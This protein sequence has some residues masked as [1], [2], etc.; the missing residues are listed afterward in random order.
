MRVGLLGGRAFALALAALFSV[1]ADAGPSPAITLPST[2]DATT[3]T[4]ST[5]APNWTYVLPI[6]LEPRSTASLNITVTASSL[7]MNNADPVKLLVRKDGVEDNSSQKFTVSGWPGQVV[8]VAEGLRKGT[9][10]GTLAFSV[11]NG[12]KT[13][14]AIKLT[15]TP[16]A[17][18]VGSPPKSS[19]D[20]WNPL[21]W[22]AVMSIALTAPKDHGVDVTPVPF[23]FR[24]TSGSEAEDVSTEGFKFLVGGKQIASA[25]TARL[26]ADTVK[27]LVLEIPGPLMPGKYQGEVKL[28]SPDLDTQTVGF[29]LTVRWFFGLALIPIL[30]GA[31][32][33]MWFRKKVLDIRPRTIVRQAAAKLQVRVRTLLGSGINLA[34]RRTLDA[35]ASR[36]DNERAKA[37]DTQEPA[38]NLVQAAKDA[39]ASEDAKLQCFAD[40]TNARRLLDSV[41]LPDGEDAQLRAK[42][43]ELGGLLADKK[44]LADDAAAGFGQFLQEVQDKL[45]QAVRLA[46]DELGVQIGQQKENIPPR[47]ADAAGKLAAASSFLQDARSALDNADF[48]S[49]QKAF[50]DAKKALI[51]AMAEKEKPPAL[52]AA[53][54]AEIAAAGGPAPAALDAMRAQVALVMNAQDS[55]EALYHYQ[56]VKADAEHA[57]AVARSLLGQGAVAQGNAAAD[58]AS[59]MG[60]GGTPPAVVANLPLKQN[61]PLVA[62]PGQ[63]VAENPELVDREVQRI[64]AMSNVFS[65]AATGALGVLVLWGADPAWGK[66]LDWIVAFFWGLGLGEVSKST[67]TGVA[68]LRST[69]AR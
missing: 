62:I 46:L 43:T 8:L 56:R 31:G 36:I 61:A 37:V 18:A 53:A 19:I 25:E 13:V 10:V 47:L 33:S 14:R 20:G 9:Y 65:I 67:F 12:A 30:L 16:A 42:W 32:A 34:E 27:R 28:L 51:Q 52:D 40:W 7:H 54:G 68:N 15:R 2:T 64:D 21:Q 50:D 69:M 45:D 60:E 48:P 26:E 44:A 11:E 39:F 35:I 17:Y 22:D 49:M 38:S 4:L 29:E 6:D 23:Q 5:A 58:W 3:V 59:L 57:R 66:P 41:R 63:V 55:H 1:M 24:R